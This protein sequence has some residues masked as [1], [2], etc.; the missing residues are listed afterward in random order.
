VKREDIR[1]DTVA[2][3]SLLTYS[4]HFQIPEYQRNYSWKA[5][6]VGEFLKDIGDATDS[7][8]GKQQKDAYLIGQIL[9]CPNDSRPPGLPANF[10]SKEVVDGQQRLTTIYLVLAMFLNSLEDGWVEQ[11]SAGVKTNWNL[12]K[13]FLTHPNDANED[14]PILKVSSSYVSYDFWSAVLNGLEPPEVD[15]VSETNLLDAYSTIEDFIQGLTSNQKRY[16]FLAYLMGEVSL[17]KLEMPNASDALQMFINLNNKGMKLDPSDILKAHFFKSASKADYSRLSEVW[18]TAQDNLLGQKQVKLI[19][20][21]QTL[22]RMVIQTKTGEYVK[23]DDLL[24]RWETYL[25]EGSELADRVRAE[26]EELPNKA[27]DLVNI[28]KRRIP[29]HSGEVLSELRGISVVRAHSMYEVLLAGSHLEGESF[30]ELSRVVEARTVL[31][32]FSK[33]A[34]NLLEPNIHPWAN[35]VLKLDPLADREEI[36]KVSRVALKAADIANIMKEI[37]ARL[38]QLKYGQ[39]DQL[40]IRYLLARVNAHLQERLN[41]TPH[42]VDTLM[43]TKTP[44]QPNGYDIDHLFPKAAGKREF[45]KSSPQQDALQGALDRSTSI[46]NSIGNLVLLK[47]SDNQFSNDSLPSDTDKLDAYSVSELRLCQLLH[48]S[49]RTDLLSYSPTRKAV[50]E[51]GWPEGLSMENWG[52]DAVAEL[53]KFY[54]RIFSSS[55]LDDLGIESS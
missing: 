53:A 28:S 9:L 25:G 29:K 6:E 1:F 31:H 10:D 49:K 32:S 34:Y 14:E 21:M 38:G 36:L 19:T 45:W 52:E 13:T 55:L 26:T 35:A 12:W 5:D 3:Q 27:E 20:S 37:P 2:L 11:Q 24:Q 51:L 43:V 23:N 16:D 17:I 39:A 42:S 33:S 18:G 4:T 22:L 47:G 8:L 54:V 50:V 44:T 40:R 15:T 7:N 46:L 48:P 30:T 41:V